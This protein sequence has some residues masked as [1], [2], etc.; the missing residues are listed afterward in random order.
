MYLLKIID[1]S[2]FWRFSS[3]KYAFYTLSSWNVEI[4]QQNLMMSLCY[5]ILQYWYY[6]NSE[7]N[8]TAY[9]SIA[10]IYVF[11]EKVCF[12]LSPVIEHIIF[13]ANFDVVF[14]LVCVLNSQLIKIMIQQT[15]L[16]QVL[17]YKLITGVTWKCSNIITK[18]KDL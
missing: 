6:Q 8:T 9:S 5:M 10:N 13:M 18:I 1:N 3:K 7:L 17:K 12:K 11:R 4:Y 16:K 14:I 15:F 2:L